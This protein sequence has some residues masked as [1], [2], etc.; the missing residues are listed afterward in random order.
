MEKELL[1][2]E[3][4]STF[5]ND[6]VFDEDEISLEISNGSVLVENKSQDRLSIIYKTIPVDSLDIF[7]FEAELKLLKSTEDG[8]FGLVLGWDGQYAEGSLDNCLRLLIEPTGKFSIDYFYDKHKE[9]IAVEQSEFIKQGL[10]ANKI[11]IQKDEGEIHFFANGDLIFTL[12]EAEL[13]GT[14]FGFIVG[15]L[16]AISINSLYFASPEAT[17]TTVTEEGD[18]SPAEDEN[19]QEAGINIHR[20][21]T[22]YR[23]GRKRSKIKTFL[24]IILLFTWAAGFLVYHEPGYIHLLL[25]FALLLTIIRRKR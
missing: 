18:Q 3:D 8:G 17:E 11:I 15:P 5:T 13:T 22:G 14:Q 1:V 4:L 7:E 24:I 12:Q 23:P 20:D 6:I 10:V 21:N 16:T 9:L 19:L 25:V 2:V